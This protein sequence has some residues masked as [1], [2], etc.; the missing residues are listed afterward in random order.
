MAGGAAHQLA[1]LGAGLLVLVR[2]AFLPALWGQSVEEDGVGRPAGAG[3][4]AAAATLAAGSARRALAPLLTP[5]PS[6]AAASFHAWSK[7]AATP[8][9]MA[10][11]TIPV[12][13]STEAEAE[14]EGLEW[15]AEGVV[16]LEAAGCAQLVA[17][18]T[19]RC[20]WAHI[21][22]LRE[23]RLQARI[24]PQRPSPRD[25]NCP[26]SHTGLSPACGTRSSIP[27]PPKTLA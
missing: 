10:A 27:S 18:A 17:P 13:G 24:R 22:Q 2:G 9:P 4:L 12:K 6:P 14:G 5:P 7:G 25:A 26:W 20:V 21:P 3:A 23:Q 8:F 16:A 19:R 15:L 1:R 11:I